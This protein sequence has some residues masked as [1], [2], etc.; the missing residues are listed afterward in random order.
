MRKSS[1]LGRSK[2]FLSAAIVIGA[3]VFSATASATTLTPGDWNCS[4]GACNQTHRAKSGECEPAV[5]LT[6]PPAARP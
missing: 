6:L 2:K 5:A 3:A 4:S 1:T